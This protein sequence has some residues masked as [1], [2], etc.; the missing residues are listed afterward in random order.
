M[1]IGGIAL[2][3][4]LK[5]LSMTDLSKVTGKQLGPMCSLKTLYCARC[6]LLQEE[7]L[8]QLILNSHE[9]E[10]LDIQWCDSISNSLI[11][12]VLV[13]LGNREKNLKLKIFA[14]GTSIDIKNINSSS[15]LMEISL[16]RRQEEFDSFVDGDLGTERTGVSDGLILRD[17]RGMIFEN[18]TS[19]KNKED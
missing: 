16:E 13:A 8:D 17:F 12:I 14:K 18:R 7:G 2:L 6:P 19:D 5:H 1:G 4:E 15:E 3:P 10:Q 9:L 11:D